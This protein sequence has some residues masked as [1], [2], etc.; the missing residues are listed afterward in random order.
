M[1]KTQEKLTRVKNA[2]QHTNRQQYI[3]FRQ[4]LASDVLSSECVTQFQRQLYAYICFR[5]TKMKTQNK[6]KY[7]KQ[8]TKKN[9]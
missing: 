4:W 5:S 2:H 7:D 3:R 6:M 1:M 8:R 9:V